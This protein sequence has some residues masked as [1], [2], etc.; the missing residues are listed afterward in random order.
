MKITSLINPRIKD[1]VRLRDRKAREKSGL[2][3]VEGVREIQCAHAAGV[4]FKEIYLCRELLSA[5]EEKDW[6]TIV[7][8]KGTTVEETDRKVF[9]K[10]SY[11]DRLEGALGVCVPPSLDLT[12]LK[13]RSS[14]L[15]VVVEQAEKP[16]NLG[17]IL[18][19]CDAAGVDALIVCGQTDIYNPNVIR[20]SLGTVFA[21]PVAQAGNE[22]VLEY[23][24]Q[25]KISIGAA[26]PAATSS[27]GD[28]DMRKSFAIVVGSE[29]EGLSNFWLTKADTK[30]KIPMRGKADSLNLSV[31]TAILIYEALRQ[32]GVK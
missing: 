28:V 9:E 22:K 30:V 6:A 7:S 16:G 13:L 32:R 25:N 14:A 12:K 29:E 3:I 23:L 5:K 2:T 26:T 24:K 21:V 19:T 4:K 27:Y 20:A 31:S 11:G 17:A 8:Q 18:R 15:I 10:I 1:I